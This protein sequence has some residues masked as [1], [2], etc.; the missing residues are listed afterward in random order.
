MSDTLTLFYLSQQQNTFGGVAVTQKF[1]PEVSS[2]AWF[3]HRTRNRFE[4]YKPEGPEQR[5]YREGRVV[6]D[7]LNL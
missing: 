7:N 3:S 5:S 1:Y 2:S 4:S 6:F